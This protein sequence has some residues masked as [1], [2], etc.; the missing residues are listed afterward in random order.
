[1]P[2]GDRYIG[3]TGFAHP[4]DVKTAERA[5]PLVPPGWRFM[6][7]ILVSAKTLAG[8]APKRMRYPHIATARVLPKLLADVGAWPVI[9]YNTQATGDALLRELGLLRDHFPFAQG[10]QLNVVRPDVVALTQFRHAH[11]GVELILQLNR[12][13]V[14]KAVAAKIDTYAAAYDGVVD[15]ALFDFSGGSGALLDVLLGRET[16]KAW[17]RPARLGVAGGLSAETVHEIAG[18]NCSCDAE[19]GLRNPSDGLSPIRTLDY[20]RAAAR[21]VVAR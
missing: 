21:V 15:H 12:Q 16:R 9:H 5:V 8:E 19:S 1:M 11:G 17:A 3:A 10:L 18:W 6:A 20:V 4:L 14:P 7:G 2:R 13:S